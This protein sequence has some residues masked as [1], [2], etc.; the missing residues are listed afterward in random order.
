MVERRFL[1]IVEVDSGTLVIGDPG[2]ILPRRDSG[3]VGIDY[4]AVLDADMS[5]PAVGLAG[6]PVL[7]IQHFGGDGP[8]GV[9]GEFED[10]EFLRL[11]VD[12]DPIELPDDEVS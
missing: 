3:E 2:Y 11:Y 4:Q 5:Q 8:Y 12:F 9:Y 6:Q 7:L 1:G 10:G